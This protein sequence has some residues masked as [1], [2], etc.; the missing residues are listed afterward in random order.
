M[1]GVY[2]TFAR[3]LCR[4]SVGGELEVTYLGG[5]L[6]AVR[7]EIDRNPPDVML[8]CIGMGYLFPQGY[9]H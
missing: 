5:K 8:G 2:R 6:L 9:L 7:V 4:L 1:V 3:S